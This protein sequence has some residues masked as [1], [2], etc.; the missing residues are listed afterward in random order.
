MLG[1]A[2]E[3][4]PFPAWQ[5]QHPPAIER[6]DPAFKRMMS[7][8]GTTCHSWPDLFRPS[9]P[10]C[11]PGFEAMPAT[12]ASRFPQAPTHKQQWP[13]SSATAAAARRQD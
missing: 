7:S 12:S 1:G 8:D 2:D 5:T 6:A 11:C 3:T 9:A 13:T 10:L 4:H